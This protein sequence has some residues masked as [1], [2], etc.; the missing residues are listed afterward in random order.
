MLQSVPQSKPHPHLEQISF[1]YSYK[2]DDLC[3]IKTK[4]NTMNELV[5]N[6][7]FVDYAFHNN[8]KI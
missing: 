2:L 5:Y 1:V 4:W 3:V 8:S 6:N 7:S